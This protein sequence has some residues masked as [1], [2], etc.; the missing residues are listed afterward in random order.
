M[1]DYT[2]KL[3]SRIYLQYK[4]SPKLIKW[5]LI[6]PEIA[7]SNIVEQLEKIRNILDIDNAEGEQLNICGR[8][9][10]LHKRPVIKLPPDCVE[11]EVDDDIFRI[12]IKAKIF[13]NNSIAT[14]DDIK[15]AADYLLGIDINV[16][17]GQDMTMRL[18]WEDDSVS[19]AVQK[20]VDN[21][22]LIPRPQ[23]V[24][25]K[26]HRVVKY[27]PFGFGP[28]FSNFNNAPFWYGDGVPAGAGDCKDD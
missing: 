1:Y 15:D 3:K 17:D 26:K 21:Y 5:L 11:R 16:L 14:I 19:V 12:L 25:M 27:K 18:V 7:K 2:E 4:N 9:A 28:H 20:L 10:G 8:I 13:K 23:G 24:G 22:D 6:L